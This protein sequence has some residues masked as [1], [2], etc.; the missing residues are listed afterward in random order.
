MNGNLQSGGLILKAD[1]SLFI[2]D[3]KN[4]SGTY[5]LDRANDQAVPIH[6]E[7]LFWFMN[8]AGNFLYYS[9]Q[10][11]GNVLCKL[12]IVKQHS[13][14]LLDKPCYQLQRHEDWIYYIHEED[15]RLY[16][17]S[18]SGKRDMRLIDEHVE[19]YLL[20]EGQIYYATPNGIKRSTESGEASEKISELVTSLLIRIGNKL[21]FSDA[22]NGHRLTLLDLERH[23][24]TMVDNI[25]ALSIS[26]DDKYIYCAN[27]LNDN[28][29]YRVDPL[30]GG[31]IRISGESADYLHVLDNDLYFCSGRE[32]HRISLFGGE[33]ETITFIGR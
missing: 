7:G 9:D 8:E 2:T 20:Y 26:T 6:Y 33:A 16:R 18:T 14:V 5:S 4:Y 12:D 31:S 1:E 22:E 10:L 13:E 25:V 29:I 30:H 27:R 24:V 32:W 19:S 17:C 23:T 15:H 28:S 11:K 21:C 3:I